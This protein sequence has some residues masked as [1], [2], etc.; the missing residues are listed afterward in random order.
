MTNPKPAWKSKTV[1]FNVVTFGVALAEYAIGRP[2]S[3]A[4]PWLYEVLA[5]LVVAGNL[6][7]RLWFTTQP[8]GTEPGE[9]T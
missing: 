2:F 5:G 1:W 3:T 7:L 6:A 8:I 4:N 9:N